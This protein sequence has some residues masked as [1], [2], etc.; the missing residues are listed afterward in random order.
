MP[1]L[2]LCALLAAL[3]MAPALAVAEDKEVPRPEAVALTDAELDEVTAGFVLVSIFNPGAPIKDEPGR[4]NEHRAVCINCGGT[5]AGGAVG[6]VITPKGD[7][8]LVGPR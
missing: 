7:M 8:K 3:S 2:R 5:N 6:I 4:V 1:K